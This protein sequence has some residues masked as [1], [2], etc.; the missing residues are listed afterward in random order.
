MDGKQRL[1]LMNEKDSSLK[2]NSNFLHI[3]FTLKIRKK[4]KLLYNASVRESFIKMVL[5]F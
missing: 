5:A 1:R 4:I 2:Y 3:T